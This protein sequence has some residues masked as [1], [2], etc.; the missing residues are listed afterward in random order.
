MFVLLTKRKEKSI[1]STPSTREA[2]KYNST[3]SHSLPDSPFPLS[4]EVQVSVIFTKTTKYGTLK[5]ILFVEKINGAREGFSGGGRCGGRT[6]EWDRVSVQVDDLKWI[7][8]SLLEFLL[9]PACGRCKKGRG[10]G[11]R[12]DGTL[13]LQPLS[14]FPFLPIPYPLNLTHARQAVTQATFPFPF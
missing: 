2:N 11:K 1:I 9:P 6:R 3:E 8:Y 10:R 12:K 4:L 5:T 14:L 13:S 7:L